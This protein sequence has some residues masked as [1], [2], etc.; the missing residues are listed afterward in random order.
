MG[1]HGAIFKQV[2]IGGDR[3]GRLDGDQVLSLLKESLAARS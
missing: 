3:G 2:Y 1:L